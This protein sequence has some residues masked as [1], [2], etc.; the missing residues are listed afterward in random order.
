M[1]FPKRTF[2]PLPALSIALAGLL[3][4]NASTTFAQS[5]VSP[6][7][8]SPSTAT[9]TTA[10]TPSPGGATGPSAPVA[11]TE[12]LRWGLATLRPHFSYRFLYG[13]G[14]QASPG[15]AS[16]TAIHSI[17]PGLL[18]EV[19]RHWTLDYTPTWNFY[20]DAAFKDTVDQAGRLNWSTHYE[21][22]TLQASQDYSR[23]NSP[24]VETGRQTQQ[25]GHAS[26][27]NALFEFGRQL[28]LETEL[29][30]NLRFAEGFNDTRTW[31]IREMLHLQTSTKV[32]TAIGAEYSYVKIN[33]APD[34]STLQLLSNLT[35]RPLA[36][37]NLALQAGLEN[38]RILSTAATTMSN[39]VLSA[40]LLYIPV[41]T[42]QLGFTAARTTSAS[43]F[44]RQIM[45]TTRWGLSLQQRLLQHFQLSASF[46][47]QES[48]FRTTDTSAALARVDKIDSVNLGLRTTLF[49]WLTT[50]LTYQKS[51]N[52]SNSSGFS[53]TSNQV[54]L[55]LG[56]R[57]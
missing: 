4:L 43:Y 25:T 40:T 5:V 35:W 2:C 46:D 7:N 6:I 38:R 15:N 55:E 19:G 31:T 12:G 13:D 44:D 51:L 16:T 42:T 20:S 48:R 32:D 11:A 1:P 41:A 33:R 52:T 34:M 8:A 18:T 37:F 29:R 17:A 24:L 26:S 36:Q 50:S 14:I 54:G 47:H 3:A 28:A 10:P 56:Y 27:L 23:T 39:P 30:Q 45:E 57:F 53:F 49:K 22:W 21:A 9:Q